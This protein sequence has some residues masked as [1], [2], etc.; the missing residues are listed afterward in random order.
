MRP[1][2]L[3]L[4]LALAA[5]T[6]CST[7][8]RVT[9][10]KATPSKPIVS[11]APAHEDSTG[12]DMK[13]NL[14]TALQTEGLTVK[15]PVP[16]ATRTQADVDAIVAYSDVWRW[17][18]VMY[19]RSISVNMYDAQNGDLLV[20]GEWND[21]AMHGFRNAKET[22]S[23]LVSEMVGTLRKATKAAGPAPV[24]AVTTP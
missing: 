22:L 21:S 19:I 13:A 10:A 3:A 23:G 8:Q 1:T 15:A 9:L 7:T 18:I 4:I 6:G 16:A 17:D 14:V 2:T 24:A 20:S 11:V 12:V 5:L